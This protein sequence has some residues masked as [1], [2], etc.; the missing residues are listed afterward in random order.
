MWTS[1]GAIIQLPLPEP[2]SVYFLKN[3]LTQPQHS[4]L[5]RKFT[6]PPSVLVLIH[7]PCHLNNVL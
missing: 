3:P 6:L 5:N 7:R 2:A 1:S 4:I